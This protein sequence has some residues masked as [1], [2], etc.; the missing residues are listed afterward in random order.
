M[1]FKV[2]TNKKS[3]RTCVNCQKI[4]EGQ[5]RKCDICS[6]KVIAEEVV[7]ESFVSPDDW[8]FTKT[9]NIGQVPNVNRKVMMMGEPVLLNPIIV[10]NQCKRF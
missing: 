9:L 1:M 10:I 4:Y 8:P 7:S 3:R 5:K 2:I 6:S